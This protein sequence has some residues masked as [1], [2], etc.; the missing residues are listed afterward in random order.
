MDAAA[1][2]SLVCQQESAHKFLRRPAPSPGS[3]AC[4]RCC[5]LDMTCTQS[6]HLTAGA[7]AKPNWHAHTLTFIHSSGYSNLA[8]PDLSPSPSSHSH[9]WKRYPS[10]GILRIPLPGP[11]PTLGLVLEA[12]A[13]VQSEMAHFR[14]EHF[15][16]GATT[17]IGLT[18]LQIL[19]LL[20]G[21]VVYASLAQHQ[22]SNRW[23]V[24]PS[25]WV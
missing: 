15:P 20:V 9:K 17:W 23:W 18:C 16:A 13:A 14:D 21:T 2:T 24:L 11:L 3:C 19:L 10:K 6:W 4:W 8:Q 1:L 25:N 7:A 22:P 12:G 5:V